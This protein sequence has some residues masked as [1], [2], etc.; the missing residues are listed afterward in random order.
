M[1]FFPTHGLKTVLEEAKGRHPGLFKKEI[2]ASEENLFFAAKDCNVHSDNAIITMDEKGRA[3]PSIAGLIMVVNN[4]I[5]L[6]YR[7][8]PPVDRLEMPDREVVIEAATRLLLIQAPGQ[9]LDRVLFRISKPD[10]FGKTDFENQ[11]SEML[12]DSEGKKDTAGG[13]LVAIAVQ[14]SK[15]MVLLA[16]D[17]CEPAFYQRDQIPAELQRLLPEKR[18]QF[19]YRSEIEALRFMED[20]I[21][22]DDYGIITKILVL[23]IIQRTGQWYDWPKH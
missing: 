6:V 15:T 12:E 8:V 19:F 20:S 21:K 4:L 14:A 11:V 7:I 16:E 2:E 3:Q 18:Q 23:S 1:K 17:Q 5:N 13:R 10:Y 9:P 22:E